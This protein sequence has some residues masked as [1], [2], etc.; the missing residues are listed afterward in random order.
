MWVQLPP[1]APPY[2]IAD[3]QI[4]GPAWLNIFGF[5]LVQYPQNVFGIL[6]LSGGR[7]ELE[8]REPQIILNLEVVRDL[9][10]RL[11]KFCARIAFRDGEHQNFEFAFPGRTNQNPYCSVVNF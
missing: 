5:C 10:L 3:S 11:E 9:R 4:Q 6:I 2:P 1:P 7:I 8:C